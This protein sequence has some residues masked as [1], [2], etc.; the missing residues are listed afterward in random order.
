M[1]TL[2]DGI[3]YLGLAAILYFLLKAFANNK[4][5]DCQIII[6][7]LFIM[8]IVI[9]IACQSFE[10]PKKIKSEGFDMINGISNSVYP[11]PYTNKNINDNNNVNNEDIQYNNNDVDYGDD[12]VNDFKDIMGIDKQRYDNIKNNEKKCHE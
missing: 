1:F 12:D 9:F 7:I 6:L 11:G 3:K 2:Q 4:M 5:S 8:L 10:C